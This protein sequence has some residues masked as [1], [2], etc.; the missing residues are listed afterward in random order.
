MDNFVLLLIALLVLQ[1][2]DAY[3]TLKVIDLGGGEGNPIMQKLFNK[4]GMKQV[5][6]V[7]GAFVIWMGYLA[8]KDNIYWLYGLVAIYVAVIVNNFIAIR[9]QKEINKRLVMNRL[10]A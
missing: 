6:A 5:F 3:T 8:G 1:I 4:F 9:K 7:K 10:N 2:L